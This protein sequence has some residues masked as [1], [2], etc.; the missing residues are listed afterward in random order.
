MNIL[1][2]N[3][4]FMTIIEPNIVGIDKKKLLQILIC[5]RNFSDVFVCNEKK[6]KSMTIL[7]YGK[8]G[9]VQLVL[10]RNPSKETCSGQKIK[11]EY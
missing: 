7:K 6:I 8:H 2:Q 11:D 4:R 3:L 10:Q 1:L 9:V 5:K